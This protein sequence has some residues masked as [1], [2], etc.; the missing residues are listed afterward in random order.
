VYDALKWRSAAS[1]ASHQRSSL[2]QPRLT[3]MLTVLGLTAQLLMAVPSDTPPPVVRPRVKAIEVSEW[4][5]RRLT[6]HRRLS[7][8]TIPLFA[9]Q[10][11]AG[12]EIWKEGP[13]ADA[14]ARNGHRVGAAALAG[15]FAVNTVT[16]VW[17]L[18]DSRAAEEGR[19]RRYLHATSMLLADAG[20]TWAGAVL[21]EQAETSSE[22]RR[23]HGAVALSSIGLSLVSG[24]IMT[25]TNK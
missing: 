15:V 22:K 9:F 13:S 16:G 10:F 11:A 19:A 25:F 23:M 3:T 14:W 1:G 18:W 8:A 20:F 12:R 2:F 7:Y 17:N 21:S 4:Y 24:L 6:L 5:D